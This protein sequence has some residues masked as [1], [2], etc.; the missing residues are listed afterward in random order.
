V[1]NPKHY[2]GFSHL[3]YLTRSTYRRARVYDSVRFRDHWVASLGELRQELGFKIMGYVVMPEHFHALLW[4]TPESDPSQIIQKLED[5]TALSIL[6]NLRENLGFPW[7]QKMLA[8]AGAERSSA[9]S[10]HSGSTQR[11]RGGSR[12]APTTLRFRGPPDPRRQ[13][14]PLGRWDRHSCLSLRLAHG[15]PP[16]RQE[17]L[18]HFVS[19]SVTGEGSFR[20]SSEPG[21]SQN[22]NTKAKSNSNGKW[23]RSNGKWFRI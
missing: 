10:V 8:R 5:R 12:T 9:A 15:A 3:H 17:C 20:G 14:S 1:S 6:K 21:E 13:A 18:R 19:R 7:C 23:Q 2:Y 4:P 22:A 11:S 16:R